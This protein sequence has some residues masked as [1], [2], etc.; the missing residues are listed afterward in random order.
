MKKLPVIVLLAASILIVS[1][2]DLFRKMA[3]RPTSKEI[4]A[5]RLL[6]EKEQLAHQNRM[7]S[8]KLMQDYISDSLA[9]LD[10]MRLSKT[11]LVA[12]RQLSEE[13]KATLKY[14]YY[15]IVGAFGKPENARNFAESARQAGYEATLISYQN[16]FLAVGVSPS[17]KLSD[18]YVSLSKVRDSGFCPDAWI[19]DNN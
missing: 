4:E 15:I 18:A 17:D 5:K 9:V 11:A 10:S 16:G 3:G 8:L 12:A 7:D 13:M 14:R 2:C 1:S 6:I 19:L